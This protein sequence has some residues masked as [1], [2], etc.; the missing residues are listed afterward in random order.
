MSSAWRL[1]FST[2]L[3]L[4]L[5]G[6]FQQAGETLQSAG[7]TAE[8]IVASPTVEAVILTQDAEETPQ[9][10]ATPTSFVDPTNRPASSGPTT[11]TLPPITIIFQPTDAPRTAEP[12]DADDGEEADA[13]ADENTNFITPGIPLGP[14]FD[15]GTE[16][17]ATQSGGA[18]TATPSGLIT[19]TALP[20]EAAVDPS[21]TYTVE[22]G[23]TVYR[24]ALAHDTSV[25]AMQEV[26]PDL[27]GENPVIQPGQVLILPDCNASMV[28]DEDDSGD[29]VRAEA[30]TTSTRVPPIIEPS[31]P[32]TTTVTPAGAP[33]SGGERYVVQPGD[34]LFI[35]AQRFGTTVAAI[36]AANE[37]ANPNRLSI[38]QELIIPNRP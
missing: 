24:I 22:S 20:D 7:S 29:V 35:I 33:N 17:S 38:G 13:Q 36:T 3:L 37:L 15:S 10:V 19:P 2:V 32:G 25:A 21:C 6:C 16:V 11:A 5:A 8:P 23:D 31:I 30:T 4:F 1:A 12:V 27:E 34:T 14:A 9:L 26:N 18:L 28:D